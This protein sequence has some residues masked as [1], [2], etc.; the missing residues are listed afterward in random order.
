[1]KILVLTPFLPYA[2]APSGCPRAVFDRVCVLAKEHEVTVVA[3]MEPHE[4]QRRAELRQRGVRVY[5]MPRMSQDRRGGAGLRRK[6]LRLAA[7]LLRPDRPMLAQEFDSHR[8]RRLVRRLVQQRSFDVVLIEHVLMAQY[9]T[10][11]PARLPVVF[12][13]HDVYLAL[14]DPTDATPGGWRG[15]L[16]RL[17]RWKWRRYEAWACRRA[18]AILVPTEEDADWLAAAIPGAHPQVVPFGLAL[19]ADTP[20]ASGAREAASLLFV[21]NFNHPPNV[22]AACWLC[23]A[24]LPQIRA[25]RPD[26]EVWLVGRDPTPAVQALAGPGIHVTGA[27]PS[28]APYL[29]RCTLFVAP[30]RQGGGMRM[31]LIEALAAGAV[32]VTTPLGAR[33]L[34]AVPGRH[35]LVADGAAPFAE[36]VLQALADPDGRA[37]LGRAGQ[38]LM[39]AHAAAG[40]QRERLTAI[41]AGVVESAGTALALMILLPALFRRLTAGRT[42]WTTITG[43]EQAARAPRQGTHPRSFFYS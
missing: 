43:A 19:E 29:R 31:K 10:A 1:M 2:T 39:A 6:R 33:G 14:P 32:V 22:D 35:L 23:G 17:D 11:V 42:A 12:T 8:T 40:D 38:A 28:V 24:I 7:G 13:E 30:L 21:G 3:F 4:R 15:L 27:V 25:A 9:L 20:A 5:G 36:T 34:G 26:V 16:T 37:A 41:L 18:A